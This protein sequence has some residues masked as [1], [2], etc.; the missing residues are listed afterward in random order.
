MNQYKTLGVNQSH[1]YTSLVFAITMAPHAD[2]GRFCLIDYL[3]LARELCDTVLNE[4]GANAPRI[5]PLLKAFVDAS[6]SDSLQGDIVL[7]KLY[8]ALDSCGLTRTSTQRV[9]HQQFVHSIL[10]WIYG[11]KDFARYKERILHESGIHPDKYNQYTLISTPRRWGKTTSVGIFVASVL[12]SVPEA[13][14]SV[15]S[16]G[17]RASKALSDLVYKFV[18]VLEE[19]AGY[20]KTR[21]IVK[22]WACV[23]S[24]KTRANE[25]WLIKHAL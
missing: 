18:M 21:V 5:V 8:T 1:K 19:T 7:A 10:P 11:K 25:S 4:K 12:F 24:L 2:D 13:W 22:A 3:P 15:Y 6:R 14:I 20:T 17:R 23:A 9:F 16:T